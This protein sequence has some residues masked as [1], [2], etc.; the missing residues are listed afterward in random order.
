MT[1]FTGARALLLTEP[2]D[3]PGV[4]VRSG[5]GDRLYR[6]R[7]RTRLPDRFGQPCRVLARGALNTCVVEFADGY[8]VSTSRN[9]VRVLRVGDAEDV[10]VR[11][12]GNRHERCS[13]TRHRAN[14]SAHVTKKNDR[15]PG[16]TLRNPLIERS[17]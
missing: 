6:W 13:S 11:H 12:G 14:R 17:V 4:P 15:A 3:A 2:C 5:S 8:Q 16:P 7:V 1:T 10:R 9:Y